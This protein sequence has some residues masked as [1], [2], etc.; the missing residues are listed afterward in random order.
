M[1]RLRPQRLRAGDFHFSLR[2]M[3]VAT[4]VCAVLLAI[5][6]A[7]FTSAGGVVILAIILLVVLFV[8]RSTVH[9]LRGY[10]AMRRGDFDRAVAAFDRAVHAHPHD[11]QHYWNRAVAHHQGGDLEAAAADYRRAIR[12]D[13]RFAAAW[14]GKATL[15]FQQGQFEQAI[16]DATVALVSAPNDL[17]ALMVRGQ[18]Y[19]LVGRGEEARADLDA[20]VNAESGPS[21]HAARG[22]ARLAVKDYQGALDDFTAVG[23]Q[24]TDRTDLAVGRSI[25]LFKLGHYRAALEQI[26]A[27]LDAD[28]RDVDALCA[29]AWFLATCPDESFR[30]GPRALQIAEEASAM[31][32]VP[33]WSC[34]ASLAAAYAECGNFALAVEHGRRA[35]ELAPPTRR[36]DFQTRLARYTAGEPFRDEPVSEEGSRGDEAP[37][38][39]RSADQPESSA[40][41]ESPGDGTDLG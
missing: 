1:E 11:P 4:T 16:A 36:D 25:A 5:S 8:D 13:V 3:L 23:P 32:A 7:T 26:D 15:A 14:S 22:H 39:P 20:A 37:A 31:L 38:E 10:S 28:A 19:L 35:L 24:G 34:E 2:R 9:A 12:L 18:A 21:Q 33:Y 27:A 6:P 29:R 30:H 17:R 40:G 41:R